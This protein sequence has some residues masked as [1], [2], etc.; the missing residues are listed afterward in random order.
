MLVYFLKAQSKIANQPGM[1]LYG[2]P[3]RW[4]KFN[5][6]VHTDQD[7]IHYHAKKTLEIK[8]AQEEKQGWTRAH[9]AKAPEQHVAAMQAKA[10]A[11]QDKASA[12]AAVT[13]WKQ[14]ILAGKVPTA[15]QAKAMAELSQSNPKK[16]VAV[17]QEVLDAVGADKAAA[18]IHAANAKVHQHTAKQAQ[19]AVA[20][21]DAALQEAIDHLEGDQGQGD[22]PEEEK[23]EDAALVD[24]LKEAIG[25][26]QD[27]KASKPA[28]K[29]DAAVYQVL[30]PDQIYPADDKLK[31]PKPTS[32]AD[33]KETAKT[34][35][36]GATAKTQ[37]PATQPAKQ[38]D[39]PRAKDI[40]AMLLA[41]LVGMKLHK[42]NTNA[43]GVNAKIAKL[44]GM[45]QSGDFAA[46]QGEKFGSNNYGKKLAKF[47]TKAGGLLEDAAKK[48]AAKMTDADIATMVLG[49]ADA[50]TKPTVTIGG[51]AFT[52]V[53]GNT[54]LTSGWADKAGAE[55]PYGSAK[56]LVADLLTTG[57]VDGEVFDWT[58]KAE[59]EKA[60]TLAIQEGVDA[61]K[62]LNK[63]LTNTH[64]TDGPFPGDTYTS[65][66]VTYTLQNGRWHRT[67]PPEQQ[68]DVSQAMKD[69][70]MTAASASGKNK[71]D[72]MHEWQTALIKGQVPTLEQA[73]A[74]YLAVP[75]NKQAQA[76]Q[77]VA[78]AKLQ[79][80]PVSQ[81]VS[82]SAE[83]KDAGAA[84]INEHA[85]NQVMALHAQA[86][87]QGAA[88]ASQ[89]APPPITTTINGHQFT[90]TGQVW[91][92]DLGVEFGP[93]TAPYLVADIYAGQRPDPEVLK[94]HHPYNLA[95]MVD[96][97]VTA[98]QDPVKVLNYVYP[99]G[100]VDGDFGEGAVFSV[101]LQDFVLKNGKWQEKTDDTPTLAVNQPGPQVTPFTAGKVT[102][103]DMSGWYAAMLAGKTPTKVQHEAMMAYLNDQPAA[104]LAAQHSLINALG[105]A[106][107]NQQMQP[108]F[109]H[110]F[111]QD[112][113]DD[114]IYAWAN[115]IAKNQTPTVK[116]A[117][118]FD[119][120][121][122]THPKI[123]KEF[124][125]STAETM[126]IDPADKA[127]MDKTIA[128]IQAMQ[129]A[130]MDGKTYREPSQ[131][132]NAK[133]AA[134]PQVAVNVLEGLIAHLDNHG[135]FS[136]TQATE[137]VNKLHD[138]RDHV[139][140]DK[141]FVLLLNLG[142]FEKELI[143]GNMTNPAQWSA[144][145]KKSLD[146]L[147]NELQNGSDQTPAPT[148]TKDTVVHGGV[149]WKKESGQWVIEKYKQPASNGVSLTLEVLSGAKL[150]PNDLKQYSSVAKDIGVEGLVMSG[151]KP[152]KALNALMPT[153]EN[154]QWPQE[155]DTKDINGITYILQNGRWHRVT[156]KD[157]GPDFTAIG[158]PNE[159]SLA[160]YTGAL[161]AGK[162]PT[163]AQHNAYLA[164]LTAASQAGQDVAALIASHKDLIDH[165]IGGGAHLALKQQ[166]LAA[167]NQAL[168]ASQAPATAADT[169]WHQEVH[170]YLDSV[171]PDPSNTNYKAVKSK[172]ANYKKLLDVGEYDKLLESNWGSNTYGKKVAKA[173][174]WVLKHSGAAQPAPIKPTVVL[175]QPI[176]AQPDTAESWNFNAGT[177]KGSNHGGLYT[178][179]NNQKWYVKIP[180]SEAH[181]RNELLAAKLY[182]AAGVAVPELK[183]V[184]SNGKVAIASKWQDGM[185]NVGAASKN[186]Q[187]ALEG[188]AVDAWLANHDS[189]GTGFDNLLVDANHQAVRIDVG[190]AL[191]F[192]AQGLPKTDFGDQVSELQ[193][194]L[195][196][197]K[198]GYTSAV[199]GGISD[200]QLKAGAA[201]VAAIT[202]DQIK[203]LCQQYG[204]GTA[205]EKASLADRLIARRDD[206]LKKHPVAAA[207]PAVAA[208]PAAAVVTSQLGIKVAD[209]SQ[210]TANADGTYTDAFGNVWKA[211]A[212]GNL[213]AAYLH[214]K[215]MQ[216]L[217]YGPEYSK[218]ATLNGQT[219]IVS[220]GKDKIPAKSA[221]Q[222]LDA[223]LQND[224]LP[225]TL[226]QTHITA[227]NQ[228]AKLK[229]DQISELATKIAPGL[230]GEADSLIQ[231]RSALLAQAG[232]ED[233][234]NRPVPDE[235]K[236]NLG[237]AS[238][239]PP[240]DFHHHPDKNGG[241]LSSVAWVNQQNT[242]DSQALY[243][244]AMQGN[245][246]ALK[247]YHYDAVDKA[248]GQSIGKK[249]ISEHPSTHI[250]KQWIAYVETLK[251]IAYPP[252]DGLALPSLG[253]YN[254]IEELSD[255]AG[256]ADPEETT[257]TVSQEKNLHFFIHLGKVD[258]VADLVKTIPWKWQKKDTKFTDLLKN[259]YAKLS[260]HIKKYIS[261][262]QA[263]GAI[264][265]V[266]SLN[267]DPDQY[268][269]A[270]KRHS[271]AAQIYEEGLEMEEGT[272]TYRWLNDTSNN[273][274]MS[275]K[276][277]DC[278]VGDVLQNTDSMCASFQ[279]HWG[280]S[281]QFGTHIRMRMRCLKGA[282]MT[283]SWGSGGYNSEGE[284][285]TLP[286]QRYIVL[287]TK[288][289][290]PG[291]ADGVD[292]DVLVL[293]P[294]DGY[295][296]KLLDL[297]KLGKALRL[298]F[299]RRAS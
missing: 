117:L 1:V 16:A 60:V 190:G 47:A 268:G 212:A 124:V 272:Q 101:G 40:T 69:A 65:N 218:L 10:K 84:N 157:Q 297:K 34:T 99:K 125:Q 108:H 68:A 194:M 61:K 257:S 241:P 279:E 208:A 265:H 5:S 113:K 78:D 285:T 251:S 287:S 234:W 71:L 76:I 203:Q 13:Y 281:P 52:K 178:D 126:G 70:A 264:N 183:L 162:V 7:Q 116:Q 227:L 271:L 292:M 149:T 215:L 89:A 141:Q 152:E 288:K 3:A 255:A 9:D 282:K 243:N 231:R 163:V 87:Q 223:F 192:R 164:A 20:T 180:K 237:N 294:H 214:H 90:K 221:Q 35:D 135:T 247:D 107:F 249:P 266:W 296:A 134:E 144:T 173:N 160:G 37:E 229:A 239:S 75:E 185:Q 181:A 119:D 39:S 49:D 256:F 280:N 127:L 131:Q 226:N 158:D 228:L 109:P 31:K 233:P 139:D 28:A 293:P 133:G 196:P 240:I 159:V 204:P 289:G 38:P 267:K 115:A 43:K 98:G 142:I 24:K 18:L 253:E 48:P 110:Q 79:K 222:V 150:S 207:K 209:G 186:A 198:N 72:L 59:Q 32:S 27:A 259:S 12:S 30:E 57:Q 154:N 244:F 274:W 114:I 174:D 25:Q 276:L 250:Q 73:G 66:G 172:V 120:F 19:A 211:E 81:L 137:W 277:L 284:L 123:A 128:K 136:A 15:A 260:S 143:T 42:S 97:L 155:G 299:F 93:E 103:P 145:I 151:M 225:T 53:E 64:P 17:M 216:T 195:D 210:W 166:M 41:E 283:P 54:W 176:A 278:D 8:A 14:A 219:L 104:C 83:A 56:H 187:G 58:T 156:P 201:K 165:A 202:P 129:A 146:E 213:P 51:E 262:V 147:K 270:L 85:Y 235:T 6:E 153:G 252:V 29:P 199:F 167:V 242:L 122:L 169:A 170:A 161:L 121:S 189:V 205:A 106:Q 175:T 275:Q 295:V 197:G 86:L 254:N 4:H 23:K 67:F 50:A 232:I 36:A 22:I 171:I 105:Q 77:D 269:V 102:D 206:L 188:F 246:Q 111:S 179:Q 55:I 193:S 177:Q 91:T 261:A 112:Q 2:K 184:M 132:A 191:L 100:G 140:H 298:I 26:N 291:N 236:L 96:D 138:I 74:I 88:S 130:A 94:Q 248:T 238:L 11:H 63:L 168:A 80:L 273:K 82:F 217:G 245:L 263:S 118:L 148:P 182:E 224:T 286:G 44:E 200:A 46:L 258:G 33:T 290:I 45:V 95:T 62:A 21:K 220:R 92:G 230:A